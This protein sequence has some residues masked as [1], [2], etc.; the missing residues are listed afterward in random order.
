MKRNIIVSVLL[1]IMVFCTNNIYAQKLLGGRIGY[2]IVA[3]DNASVSILDIN[4][5]ASLVNSYSWELKNDGESEWITIGETYDSSLHD[6]NNTQDCV[7]RRKS[8]G[9]MEPQQTAYSNNV[10]YYKLTDKTGLKIDVGANNA[11]LL[12]V[13]SIYRMFNVVSAT[14]TIVIGSYST[15]AVPVTINTQELTTMAITK[16]IIIDTKKVK[17]VEKI[18]NGNN[19][20]LITFVA[21]GLRNSTPFIL[22]LQLK[23][24]SEEIVPIDISMQ[25][26]QTPMLGT[27][28]QVK[29]SPIADE[30]N[31]KESEYNSGDK[32]KIITTGSDVPGNYNTQEN[33]SVW[34]QC[35]QDGEQWYDSH[36]SEDAR[37]AYT[38]YATSNIYIR[39]CIS[40]GVDMACSNAYFAKVNLSEVDGGEI[41]SNPMIRYGRKNY[42]I[43]S[44][45][46]AKLDNFKNIEYA[47][48][49]SFDSINWETVPE[50]KS[51][52]Y[53]PKYSPNLMYYRR[54]AKY[55]EYEAY[56]NGVYVE[57][58]SQNGGTICLRSDN[59]CIY[60]LECGT[61]PEFDSAI[62]SSVW[63]EAPKDNPNMW[64]DI[65]TTQGKD[66]LDLR[67]CQDPNNKRFRRL[68]R[69][70]NGGSAYTNE[71]YPCKYDGN[72][73]VSHKINNNCSYS[74]IEYYDGLGRLSQTVDPSGSVA[75]ASGT[76][77]DIIS[78]V[79]YDNMGRDNTVYLPFADASSDSGSERVEFTPL[80]QNYYANLYGNDGEFAYKKI[81]YEASPIDRI[82]SV[83][84]VGKVFDDNQKSTTYQYLTNYND[85]VYLLV[86]NKDSRSIMVAGYY[87]KS[88]LTKTVT[89][90]E[91][92]HMTIVYKDFF[93]NKVLSRRLNGN[94]CVDTYYVYD[95][96]NRLCAVIPPSEIVKLSYDPVVETFLNIAASASDE[97]LQC[98]YYAYDRAGNCV[99]KKIPG[100]D[101]VYY[102]YNISDT[103]LTDYPVAM[104]D[105]NLRK[106]NTW[107]L[108]D[109]D[110][111][112]RLVSTTYMTIDQSKIDSTI[113]L[114]KHDFGSLNEFTSYYIK[115][116]SSVR[117][118]NKRLYDSYKTDIA[119]EPFLPVANV[120]S[121]L[122]VDM[123]V[124]GLL[125]AEQVYLL[126]KVTPDR[127]VCKTYYYDK[128]G[129][130]VQIVEKY[131]NGAIARY[132]TKY[133][134]VG[135]VLA[136]HESHT[137]DGQTDHIKIENSLDH[138][139]R[140][141]SSSVFVNDYHDDREEGDSE[142]PIL[143][144]QYKYDD[145]GKLVAKECY[146]MGNSKIDESFT[147]NIQGW[148][149]G[150]IVHRPAKEDDLDYATDIFY[151]H[152]NYY[153][154]LFEEGQPSYIGN[155]SGSSTGFANSDPVDNLYYYDQLSRLV[156]TEQYRCSTPH[157][158]FV[159][160]DVAYDADG[161]IRQ[162]S[163][164]NDSSSS[165]YTYAY[166]NSGLL[167][168]VSN[169][170]GFMSPARVATFGLSSIIDHPV[171]PITVSPI[172]TLYKDDTEIYEGNDY[173]YDS[174][175]NVIYDGYHGLNIRYNHL[176]LPRKISRG[177]DIL[178]NYVYL[179][180]GSKYSALKGDGTG[181]IYEGSFIYK[182]SENGSLTLES[183][184]FNG[185]RFI[186]NSN[187]ELLPRYFITDH[188]GSVRGILNENFDIEE[189][190]DYYQ[191]GKHIDDPNS[192]LSDN[193]Y[194]Y[195]GKENQEFFDLPYLDYGARLYDPH[196]CRW[197]S[198]DPMAENYKDI[199][200][201]VFCANNPI[202]YIDLDGRLLGDPIKNPE[203]RR[204]QASNLFG[205]VRRNSD[206]SV[207]PHQGFDYYAPEGT[208]VLAVQDG[209][210][211]NVNDNN[212]DYGKSVTIQHDYNGESVYSFY[213]HLSEISIKSGDF[214]LE[215]S[216]I[217]KSG[218][219]GN[220]K[221]MIGKDQHL[222][223]ELRT[224]K[225]NAKGLNGKR[226]PNEIV[227][228][229]FESADPDNKF[230]RNVNVI[231]IEKNTQ[232]YE[233]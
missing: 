163:R 67:T 112:K 46:E 55:A 59:N 121:E 89:I 11:I 115:A 159:E 25:I 160:K 154:P 73:V 222:H 155:I 225:E 16:P 227:D 111:H 79:V 32:I 190:N 22:H 207:R 40:D 129:R 211:V 69:L 97:G 100:A 103:V 106:N 118:V 35:S 157:N 20:Y 57:P 174:N 224:Q 68:F 99:E 13:G 189:Q 138:R 33:L 43:S 65:P 199:N 216:I 168:S 91:D 88:S 133:D 165:V 85:E 220:A 194:H 58:F 156:N 29:S 27:M 114:S 104:Q 94:D 208:D 221:G 26:T 117:Y 93:D 187:G 15:S 80:Q 215:N 1:S 141:L 83:R 74:S 116:Q 229:K 5:N 178:V 209:L 131:P 28:G 146:P 206:D 172:P 164:Y 110:K 36:E 66:S 81:V 52:Y 185:G 132:S 120:V 54:K 86:Y 113:S 152:L 139:G 31:L 184:P 127:F 39:R 2:D 71:I 162:L 188:L 84:N 181:F 144:L 161:N 101:P 8:I 102:I 193:R 56:S 38:L 142:T 219:S 212:G 223:F 170:S 44:L 195:N 217:G 182:Q 30:N 201:Y 196:I 41:V 183:I 96:C 14:D 17:S 210:V 7:I 200:P 50:A 19:L 153:N 128:Y 145:L 230:Q 147:Y 197:L 198:I 135:N 150:K 226:N 143:S 191:F 186:S 136:T 12:D 18:G 49:K 173:V 176:N 166:D 34:W 90:D 169:N 78:P 205:L 108:M 119:T 158:A 60:Y 130:T 228:T 167:Q 232:F 126:D 149:T 123:R 218:T 75:D 37:V 231:K 192:Q 76:M 87:P 134:M 64:S 98:Y 6:F 148:L 175:G 47:W 48:E 23:N 63:Q 62:S 214:V 21:A 177:D 180:D 107:V 202:K 9:W 53:K 24:S 125:T 171:G 109:Y 77:K 42:I 61:L 151:E 233:N 122:D 95:C 179:A 213:A 124:T 203:I 204:N 140:I 3:G 70:A 4:S 92:E 72:A 105:G 45:R 82:N 10:A 137:H 51:I